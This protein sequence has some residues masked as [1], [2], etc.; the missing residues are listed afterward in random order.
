[1]AVGAGLD[2][3]TRTPAVSGWAAAGPQ[4]RTV[5]RIAG[6]DRAPSRA[7]GD[8]AR[9]TAPLYV[10][11]PGPSASRRP[12]ACR[13]ADTPDRAFGRTCT[14]E[15]MQPTGPAIEAL[16]RIQLFSGLAPADLGRLAE[17]LRTRRFRRGE[18]LFHQ[19]DPGDSLFIVS[20]R[21][22]EDRAAIGGGRRGDPHH[23]PD[24]RVLRRAG[25]ARRCAAFGD[26]RGDGADRDAGP[27]TGG[28]PG[29]HRHVADRPGRPARRPGRRAPAPDRRTSR[30]ST[31]ST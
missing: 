24:R 3:E 29:P 7:G 8:D 12:P 30:S 19:G 18:V 21:D 25:P 14:I 5:S 10:A 9:V 20:T 1:M 11:R 16:E 17:G 15:A 4:P 26:R 13:W 31:S 2:E 28:V 6:S 27:P 23:D 22:G